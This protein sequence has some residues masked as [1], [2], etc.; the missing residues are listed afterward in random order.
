MRPWGYEIEMGGRFVEIDST[1]KITVDMAG[2]PKDIRRWIKKQS[3]NTV[4]FQTKEY[5]LELADKYERQL[6]VKL[7][8]NGEEVGFP[9]CI[10]R[11]YRIHRILLPIKHGFK[12]TKTIFLSDKFVPLTDK[13]SLFV[14]MRKSDKKIKKF[15][16]EQER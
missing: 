12:K 16:E 6:W 1:R 5:Y 9:R 13:G 14:D 7:Y 2:T 15:I 11:L 3:D 4:R 8:C 10:D